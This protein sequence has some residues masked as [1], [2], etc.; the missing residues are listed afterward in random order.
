MF[1]VLVVLFS[2][3]KFFSFC[4]PHFLCL[5]MLCN[6]CLS[7]ILI[8][9]LPFLH[10]RFLLVLLYMHKKIPENTFQ[11]SLHNLFFFNRLH[12]NVPYSYFIFRRCILFSINFIVFIIFSF[13]HLSYYQMLNFTFFV[14]LSFS[15]PFWLYLSGSLISSLF[16]RF[17]CNSIFLQH[18]VY[19]IKNS[20]MW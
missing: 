10:F 18:P 1:F 4:F 15:F 3:A 12:V 19:Q 6:M 16:S 9:N 13:L 17:S 11:P 7:L 5:I 2:S 14:V 8:H 20:S